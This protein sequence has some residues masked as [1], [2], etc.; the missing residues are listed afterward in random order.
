MLGTRTGCLVIGDIGGYTTYLSGVELEHSADVLADLLQTIVDALGATLRIAKIEGDAVFAYEAGDTDGGAL[1]DAVSGAYVAFVRRQRTIATLTSCGCEACRCIPDLRLKFVAHR[2]SYATHEIAGGREL[3]G[4]DVVL[5]H[6]L[7]KNDVVAQTGM[8]DYA[9]YTDAV[10]EQLQL[11]PEVL[12]WRTIDGAYDD[13]GA[14]VGHLD[15][16]AARWRTEAAEPQHVIAVGDGGELMWELPAPPARVWEYFSDPERQIQFMADTATQTAPGGARRPG[17]SNHCVH[18]RNAYDLEVLDW[19]PYEYQA[20]QFRARGLSLLYTMN[21]DALPDGGTR[22]AV[23]LAPVG[24]RASR[25]LFRIVSRRMVRE[26]C[27]WIETLEGLLAV[28]AHSPTI[29]AT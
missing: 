11:E 2:G 23:R 25:F 26:Y 12:G 10:V 29:D 13:V 6:R 3:V 24:G 9:L 16:L 17:M 14:V 18:G 27:R 8:T 7:L 21:Y 28:E 5:V 22:L 20:W 1:V 4:R 15:D 19:I